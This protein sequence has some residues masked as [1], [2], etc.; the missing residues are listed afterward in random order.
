MSAKIQKYSSRYSF[1]FAI[2]PCISTESVALCAHPVSAPGCEVA[3]R[4]TAWKTSSEELCDLKLG[5]IVVNWA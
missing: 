4:L 1:C 3:G 2:R 5:L